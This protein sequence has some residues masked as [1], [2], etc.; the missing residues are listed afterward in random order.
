MRKAL[1]AL[2]F[3][4]VPSSVGFP[5]TGDMPVSAMP[6]PIDPADPAHVSFGGLRYLAGW[7]LTSR[8]RDF[9]GYSALA[10]DGDHFLALA[11][12]GHYLR[13]RMARPGVID[14]AR[15][16]TLPAFPANA[17]R[18]GERDSESM[19]V[20]PDGDIWVGFENYNAVLRYAPGFG[21]LVSMARPPAMRDWAVNLGAES[22][23]RLAD[24]R[25]VIFCEGKEIAPDVHAALMFPGDPA[26]R[27]NIP[28][29]FGYRPPRGYVPTDAQ[30]LPDGR[31]IVLN[32]HFGLL[33]GFW[34]A[35][36]IVDTARIAPG[37]T[38]T[39]ELVATF[40][41][42][43]NIDNMEGISVTREGGRTVI[44]MISDDNQ[45]PFEKT[46]LLKFQLRQ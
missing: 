32:R 11:D 23:A 34:A 2:L 30:Q 14:E 5:Q 37:A 1:A 27:K 40:K 19:A 45:M 41:P 24:G 44:W 22:M 21:R 28:F 39:G 15:F 12:T 36:A 46:L 33:D 9:G 3:C 42:P 43:L 38:V 25:F 13:F 20:G 7:R 4:L 17:G 6:I 35:V 31:I 16:G 29:Q 8:Q 26:D 10:V 18:P